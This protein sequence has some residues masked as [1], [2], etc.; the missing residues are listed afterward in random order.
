M[1][2]KLGTRCSDLNST[3][4]V[5]NSLGPG[6]LLV[7][8][9]TKEQQGK[10]LPR[11]ADGTLIPC[12]GLTGV[13]SG[14]D[15]TSLIG[16]YG[17]V[18]RDASGALGVRATFDKR[19]ITPAPVAPSSRPSGSLRSKPMPTMPATGASVM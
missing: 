4:A 2:A 14:S 6:E 5:P 18:E 17:T 7:R 19:Y 11:L 13:H 16:S 1:L 3:V 8:H 12:F 9:G 15:A 10:F